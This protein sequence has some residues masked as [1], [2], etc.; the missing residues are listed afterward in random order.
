MLRSFT[1]RKTLVT[2][3]QVLIIFGVIFILFLAVNNNRR[4][5]TAEPETSDQS[6][7]ESQVAAEGTR[8]IE[9]EATLSYV[10]SDD[11]VAAYARDEGG[12]LLPGEKRVVP[13]ITEAAPLPTS[14]PLPTPDPIHV[15][16]PWQAWWQLL[17]DSPLPSE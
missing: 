6:I 14:T 13:I 7:L 15:S 17:T 5:P 12:Q 1:N 4:S 16:R 11:Y 8:Q 10:Q 9:L 2:I 3:P